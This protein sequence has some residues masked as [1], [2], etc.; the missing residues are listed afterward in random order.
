MRGKIIRFCSVWLLISAGLSAC[1]VT[2]YHHRKQIDDQLQLFFAANQ[3]QAYDAMAD[4]M[5]HKLFTLSSKEDMVNA[6]EQLQ[7]DMPFSLSDL[8]IDSIGMPIVH[9][10]TQYVLVNYHYT[11]QVQFTDPN[12]HDPQVENQLLMNFQ[13]QYVSAEINN[14]HQFTL[15]VDA[16]VIAIAPVKAKRWVFFEV[17]KGQEGLWLQFLPTAVI[18]RLAFTS[19]PP[20]EE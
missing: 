17:K 4:M 10:D 11:M 6:L 12:Y 1:S 2:K 19:S 13:Q 14:Q 18:D 5:Y 7:K 3:E 8:V 9:Q 15:G 20:A 16:R